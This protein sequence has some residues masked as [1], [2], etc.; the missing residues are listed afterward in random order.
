[1]C[2]MMMIKASA[3]ALMLGAGPAFGATIAVKPAALSPEAQEKFDK[4]YGEREV[5]VLQEAITEAVTRKLQAK[6]HSVGEGGLRVEVTILDAVPNRPTFAEVTQR[7]GLDVGR[8]IGVGGASLSGRIIGANGETLA[9]VTHKWYESD[10]TWVTGAS[11]W[12]DARRAI[13]RFADKVAEA[14]PPA[15]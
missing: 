11:T 15:G 4:T 14:A 9:T 6:G 12:T 5:T 1:M 10:I 3:I 8:S 2:V 13:R 7:I